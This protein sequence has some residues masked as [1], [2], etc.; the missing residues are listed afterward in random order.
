MREAVDGFV[1]DAEQFDDLTCS[2]ST[3]FVRW[4]FM[5]ACSE[6]WTSSSKALAVRAMIGMRF[7]SSLFSARIAAAAS[8]PSISGMRTSIRIAA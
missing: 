2:G 3:G 1:K 4:A 7:A 6:R 5:P 8:R